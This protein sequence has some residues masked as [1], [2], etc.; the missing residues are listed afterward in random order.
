LL[1]FHGHF[2]VEDDF[3]IGLRDLEEAER[4]SK[5]LNADFAKEED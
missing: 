2:L 4:L 5:K 1:H 3:E